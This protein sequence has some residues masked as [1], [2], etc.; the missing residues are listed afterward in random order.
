MEVIFLQNARTDVRKAFDWYESQ[1]EGLGTRFIKEIIEFSKKI[2]RN[3]VEY[4]FYMQDVQY[5]QL[6]VF[7]F[8]IFFTKETPDKIFVIAVLHNRQ[9]IVSILTQRK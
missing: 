4:K 7:P 3:I 9:D 8:S 2:T 1:A 5:I 6:K